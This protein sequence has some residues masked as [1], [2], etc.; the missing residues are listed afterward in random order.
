[1]LLVE[2]DPAQLL[3]AMRGWRA[4]PPPSQLTRAET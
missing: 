3:T 2:R 4:P 1:M